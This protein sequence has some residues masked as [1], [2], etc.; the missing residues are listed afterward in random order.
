MIPAILNNI[1]K[2]ERFLV[3]AHG[4]PDGDA[5]ASTMALT[6]AL[7]EM[8]KTAVAYNQD[9][10]T[11]E[12]AFLPGSDTL[13]SE[14]GDNDRF[15]VGFIL[16]SG[17]LR[18]AGTHLAEHCEMLVNIDHH[19]YS[20]D[21]GSIYFVDET[22]CATGA[23]VYRIL[24]EAGQAISPQVAV[25]IYT[26]IL[27]DTGSFRYSN[28]DPEAF[29]IA[30]EMINKG[31]SPWDVA[32]NLYEN[33]PEKRLR[34]LAKALQTLTISKCGRYGS[35]SVTSEMFSETETTSEHTDGFVNYPRSVQGVEVA[36][37]FRQVDPAKFKIGFRSKGR[38]DV[39]CLAREFGG[40]GHHNAAGATITGSLDEIRRTV[41][42]R[43]DN[44]TF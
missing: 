35:I 43:L 29:R 5:L 30:A 39:G 4:N 18:R 22:A 27:A 23:L 1:A 37:F 24:S 17:E 28:A 40:G 9:G 44:L 25:C 8:G 21:F 14:L 2:G 42:S 34:L 10:L 3:A 11:E 20:E 31:V 19:P 13:V 15:D 38:V 6:L 32:S 26:A 36:L 41:F 33:R 16:D 12:M 7:R